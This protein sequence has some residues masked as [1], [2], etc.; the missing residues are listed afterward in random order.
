MHRLRCAALLLLVGCQVAPEKVAVMPLPEGGEPL[1]YADVVQRARSQASAANDAFYVDRWADLQEAANTLEKTARF[2]PRA[3]DVPAA[4]KDGLP[5][6]ADELTK[7]AGQLRDAAK[8]QDVKK[9]NEAL[10]QINL[11][12]RELRAEEK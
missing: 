8:A 3:T 12:V 4:L 11:K 6:R 2:L 9:T 7:L 5:T 1:A 10:Q